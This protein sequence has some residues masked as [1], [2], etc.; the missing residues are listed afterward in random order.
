[1][2]LLDKF[3]NKKPKDDSF[4]TDDEREL[5]EYEE[6]E[7]RP[8][9]RVDESGYAEFIVEDCFVIAGRGAVV[10]G[11]VTGGTFRTGDM[12]KVEASLSGKSF[13]TQITGIEEF[14]KTVSSV[15]EGAK[16]GLLLKDVRRDQV[17]RNV[18]VKKMI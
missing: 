10:V 14:R 9:S 1:M 6:N 13:E 12:V 18:I 16:A 4:M 17:S 5:R 11:T 8:E 2:G 7:Y 15:S 3:L